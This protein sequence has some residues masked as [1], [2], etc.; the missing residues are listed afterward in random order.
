M[1]VKQKETNIALEIPFMLLNKAISG[2][3]WPGIIKTYGITL[4]FQIDHTVGK[5]LHGWKIAAA[6][7][8]NLIFQIA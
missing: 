5:K 1:D 7:G 6:F 2:H 3:W 4:E 8:K